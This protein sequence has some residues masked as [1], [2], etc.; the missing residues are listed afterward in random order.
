MT[1]LSYDMFFPNNKIWCDKDLEIADGTYEIWER[2]VILNIFE[3]K[4]KRITHYYKYNVEMKKRLITWLFEYL[5]DDNG[6]QICNV[7]RNHPD[8]NHKELISSSH[9]QLYPEEYKKQL[10]F[11]QKFNTQWNTFVMDILTTSQQLNGQVEEVNIDEG[12]IKLNNNK[13]A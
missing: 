1:S 5:K 9:W 6:V 7:Y 11:K 8:V 13:T 10:D 4:N 2:D 3:I 12:Y